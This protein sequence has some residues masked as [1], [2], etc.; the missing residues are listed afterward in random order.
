[1]GIKIVI[2][3]KA[4]FDAYADELSKRIKLGEPY[5]DFLTLDG[6]DGGSG[7][8]PMEMMARMG[9]SIQASLDI[10]VNALKKR[11]IR[12]KVKII[13][14]EKVL[15]P[16]DVIELFAYGADFINIARGFMISAGCIRARECSGANGK[17]CPVG[18]A[19][20]NKLKRSK[21]LIEQKSHNIARY[22]DA[23]IAGVKS[24][25]AVMGKKSLKELSK[26]DLIKHPNRAV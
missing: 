24:L 23:L 4:N 22:H 18:I 9:L 13:A 3:T 17:D 10:V 7:A 12:E 14:S 20:M 16:D 8:A 2:S 15:T 21:F 6:G 25:M 11:G 26:R 5:P 19:T 1:M